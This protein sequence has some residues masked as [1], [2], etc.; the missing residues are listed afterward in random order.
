M[1]VFV[2][3][4]DFEL[5]HTDFQFVTLDEYL[6]LIFPEYLPNGLL[7]NLFYAVENSDVS[8]VYIAFQRENCFCRFLLLE[9]DF[10]CLTLLKGAKAL[11]VVG[12]CHCSDQLVNG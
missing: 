6:W 5:L 8:C 3:L 7:F 4:V 9:S 11:Q 12:W 1:L 2:E 10:A